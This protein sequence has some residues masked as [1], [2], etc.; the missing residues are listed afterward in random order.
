MSTALDIVRRAYQMIGYIAAIE[1]LSGADTA[2]GIDQLNK[3]LDS[4]SN[5]SLMAYAI[6]EQSTV[7]VP[8]KT[9][10]TIGPNGDVNAPRPLKLR[11]GYGAAYLR[12]SNNN[13]YWVSVVQK[14][15]W[16]LISNRGDTVVS[17]IPDTLFYDPQFPLGIINVW[18]TPT[19]AMTLFWD[20][21]LALP[22]M[23]T[24]A[25]AFSLPPGYELA[26]QSNLAVLLGPFVKG[27]LV[28]DDVKAIARTS[29]ASIK[30]TNIR[31]NVAQFDREI[32]ENGQRSYNVYTDSYR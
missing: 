15:R 20:S 13:N 22:D 6:L 7:L 27:A 11:D 16:N 1:P 26:L 3:M 29:K 21:Y 30:R 10:Y 17:N 23:P 12:D 5:E 9:A 18:P 19:E 24:T 28:S 25:T 32:A 4:W 31:L 2:L 8:G 14:D